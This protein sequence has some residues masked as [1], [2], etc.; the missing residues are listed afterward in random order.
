MLKEYT[1]TGSPRRPVFFPVAVMLWLSLLIVQSIYLNTDPGSIIFISAASTVIPA[2]LLFSVVRLYKAERNRS[3]FLSEKQK[4]LLNEIRELK[5]TEKKALW[6]EQFLKTMADSSP[7]G[8][9][10]FNVETDRVLYVNGRFFQIWNAE[11]YKEKKPQER[12][13]IRS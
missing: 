2:Y 3:V 11:E 4:D 1:E 12:S 7:R 9:V 10:A 8:I 6:S 13:A 5:E